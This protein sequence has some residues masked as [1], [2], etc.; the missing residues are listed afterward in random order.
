M[1]KLNY[2]YSCIKLGWTGSLPYAYRAIDG[3]YVPKG[4]NNAYLDGLS[5]THG[6]PRKHIWSYAAG[7][8]EDADHDTNCPCAAHPG[9]SPPSFV[10]NH[11]HCESGNTGPWEAQWYTSDP[12]WDGKGCVAGSDCCSTSRLPWFCR[13]LPC[14]TTDHIEVRWCCDEVP[15]NEEVATELLEIYII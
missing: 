13:T 5:I 6:S 10:G 12:L 3:F 14:E 9:R 7:V 11:Y 8:S 1:G 2:E 15:S 4:T